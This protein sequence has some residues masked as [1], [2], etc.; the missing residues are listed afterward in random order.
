MIVHGGVDQNE[1]S[2]SD[3]YILDGISQFIDSDQLSSIFTAYIPGYDINLNKSFSTPVSSNQIGE[4]IGEGI[5][6][7]TANNDLN[8]LQN[9][10]FN[11][12]C[13]TVNTIAPEGG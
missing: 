9:S 13:D 7:T 6:P 3:T 8:N 2:F 1:T 10:L 11:V 4:S 12:D 5:F